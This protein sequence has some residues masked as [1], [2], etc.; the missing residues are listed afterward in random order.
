[1]AYEDKIY[2][3]SKYNKDSAI[4]EQKIKSAALK[5]SL[6]NTETLYLMARNLNDIC[7]PPK[8]DEQYVIVTEKSFNAFALVLSVIEKSIIDELYFAI[9]R[10]N[11][12]T[13]NSLIQFIREGKIKQGGFIISNFFNQTKKPEK[14]AITLM[15]FCKTNDDFKFCYVHNHAKIMCLKE[16]DNYFVFEG[17]GNMSDNARIEQYRYDNSQELYEFHKNW[18]Q[19]LF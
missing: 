12:P 18:M 4:E 14:W 19:S 10:I 3:N 1:M 15:E 13:V 11:E 17:S 9:Y 2:T 6:K 7:R 16:S 5:R 8:K